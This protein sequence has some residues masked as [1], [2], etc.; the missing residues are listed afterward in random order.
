MKR[1]LI[2]D[3]EPNIRQLINEIL[4]MLGI[5]A[6]EAAD[7]PEGFEHITQQ[8]FACVFLDQRM[9]GQSGLETLRQIRQV[10]DVPVYV[11]SAYQHP[12]EITEMEQLGIS[13]RIMKP[14]TIDELVSIARKYI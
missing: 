8:S 13:G 1:M 14:F 3:D 5:E 6:V 7:G 12:E 2:V 10:S 4:A 11:I 9:P